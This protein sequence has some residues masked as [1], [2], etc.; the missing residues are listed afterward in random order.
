MDE[1]QQLAEV[2]LSKVFLKFAL[3]LGSG[4]VGTIVLG[5]VLLLTWSVVGEVLL[6]TTYQTVNEFGEVLTHREETH[7]LFLSVVI[8]AVFLATLVAN[9]FHCMISSTV[10]SKYFRK[11]TNLTQAF[12]GNLCILFLFIPI[13]IISSGV[14]GAPG[15]A[16]T[17]L[18]HA[19]IAS[20]FTF[21]ALEI[22]STRRYLLV[23]LYGFITGLALFFIVMNMIGFGNPTIVTFLAL[24]LL[25]GN[26]G[27]GSGISQMFY[28]WLQETYHNDFLDS[29]KRFGGDYG[30][31]E[32]IEED[33]FDDI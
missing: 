20:M 26:I 1:K 23:S 2:T 19:I 30:E 24:P 5:I 22:L 17:A 21:L 7:P 10:E 28:Y 15:V 6:P 32:E 9:L 25:L 29:E 3:G 16:L 4:G 11:S 14:Y 8:L 33:G 31:K 13:Y 27:A 18:A 12:L